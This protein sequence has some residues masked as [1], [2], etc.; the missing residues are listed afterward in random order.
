[1]K[2]ALEDHKRQIRLNGW[3]HDLLVDVSTR[4]IN[5]PVDQVDA[6]VEDTQRLICRHLQLDCSTLWQLSDDAPDFVLL[7]HAYQSDDV[8]Q[9]SNVPNGRLPTGNYCAFKQANS[10]SHLPRLNASTVIPWVYQRIRTG[11]TVAIP[12]LDD[13]PPEAQR[14]GDVLRQIGVHSMV[15][16]PLRGGD[17]LRG[18]LAFA[19]MSEE[20][21]WPKE[22]IGQFK[23]VANLFSNALLRKTV[24]QQVPQRDTLFRTVANC[25][26]VLLWMTDADDRCVFLNEHWLEFTGRSLTC[27]ASNVWT[28]TVHPSDLPQ[29]MRAFSTPCSARDSF[30]TQFRMRRRDGVYRWFCNTGVPQFDSPGRFTGYIGSCIDISD[31]KEAEDMARDLSRRLIKAQE[32]E[33]SR[34]AREL[35]DDISQR[36]ARLA[37]DMGRVERTPSGEASLDLIRSVHEGLISVSEDVHSLSYRL[38]P[39]SLMDLGLVDALKSECTKVAMRESIIIDVKLRNLPRAIPPDAAIAMFRIAQEAMRN[40]VRHGRARRIDISMRGLDSGLQ[41]AV[42]DDGMGFDLA[43][44]RNRPSLGLASMRERARLLG[45]ELD[46]ESAP[47]EGTTVIAWVPTTEEY[48]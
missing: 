34:L 42:R 17:H 4:L 30:V 39:A 5:L 29:V 10:C 9:I 37:I 18:C 48:L 31:R 38:H 19:S 45:G 44:H 7:T 47:G 35:H 46:I 41:L 20:C 25:A 14:D 1:V 22:I 32:E 33:R 11:Q 12:K 8:A 24:E 21:D 6:A 23:L 3:F 28:D 43:R 36:L 13:L 16:V 26:P 15:A 2:A 40:A 27:G